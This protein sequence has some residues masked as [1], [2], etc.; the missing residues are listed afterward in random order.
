MKVSKYC[1]AYLYSFFLMQRVN[2][3]NLLMILEDSYNILRIYFNMHV[4]CVVI[5]LNIMTAC[6]ICNGKVQLK[7]LSSK[8]WMENMNILVFTYLYI[9]KTSFTWGELFS[10]FIFHSKCFVF[11]QQTILKYE[12]QC[13]QFEHKNVLSCRSIITFEWRT[14]EFLFL[15]IFFI[16][17]LNEM[18]I[19]FMKSRIHR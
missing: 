10:V 4:F 17:N 8:K 12:F 5:F 16:L 2:S 6:Y 13:A 11:F 18:D 3:S 7:N 14:L 9:K 15:T 19:V 1:V